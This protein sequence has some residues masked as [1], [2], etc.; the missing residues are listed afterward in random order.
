MPIGRP[1]RASRSRIIEIRLAWSS[2]VPC[3]KFSLNTSTPA[4]NR[5]S[6]IAAVELAGPRVE[7]ILVR[8]W[9]PGLVVDMV[10]AS[11]SEIRAA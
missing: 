3:E 9:W 5:R 7:T 11:S 10:E 1:L 8:R 6:I 2:W 4:S